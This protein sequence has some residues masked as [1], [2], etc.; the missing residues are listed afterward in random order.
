MKLLTQGNTY[1]TTA[2]VASHSS[3]NA[4]GLTGKQFLAQ[5]SKS[6]QHCLG[7]NH[8]WPG[9]QADPISLDP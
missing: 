2:G 9:S 5:E 3:V 8:A 6:K 7:N 1:T 4:A